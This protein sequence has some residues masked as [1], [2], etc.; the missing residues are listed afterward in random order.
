MTAEEIIKH[1]KLEPLAQ[2]GG[3]FRETHRSAAGMML[4]R[5]HR[6]YFTNILYLV[7]PKS[8]SKLHSVVQE[9]TFHFCLGDPAEMLQ[10]SPTGQLERIE[11][12]FDIQKGQTLQHVVP[13]KHFQGIR[14]L[15]GGK[16]ALFGCTVAPG[17]DYADFELA[18]AA[19][20]AAQYPQHITKLNPLLP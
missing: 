7:T 13:S 18:D 10:L 15:P 4:P 8:F 9:E 2:E 20:I 3:F 16:W 14:L 17:F 6:S 19:D 11:F 12:G 1:L 5:G